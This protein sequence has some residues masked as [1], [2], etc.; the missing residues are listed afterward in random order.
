MGTKHEQTHILNNLLKIERAI[1]NGDYPNATD[2]S[3]LI[4][5]SGKTVGRYIEILKNDYD[6]P[7]EF[8][9]SRN[10]YYYT[11]KNFFIQNIMLKEGELL[12]ISAILPLLEQYKN[13]PLEENFRSIMSKITNML[14]D[15]VSVDSS[16]VNNEIHFISDPVTKLQNGVFNAVLKATKAHKTMEF[17]YKTAQNKE[18]EKREFN[19]YHLICQKG[20]WYVIGYS[21]HAKDIRLY[22]MP[23]IRNAKITEKTFK[24]PKDFKLENHI[25]PNYGTWNTTTPHF[26][27]ELL[28]EPAIKTY[29]M[30]REWHKDQQITK[31]PD[32]SV[33]LSFE[34]NRLNQ[35]AHWVLQLGGA[36][37]VLNPPELT[38]AVKS[39]AKKILEKY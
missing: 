24:I 12:T 22:A 19:P 28:I 15:N 31:N 35:T 36:A 9:F 6:A 13:T 27:V 23:R 7:I 8:N 18:H 32:G 1:R 17:E 29:V 16:L 11:D 2:L 25:D 21:F 26:K 37:K 10:G 14:P 4:E 38:D 33:L 30:E 39:I 3:K 20:S 34:T 5:K